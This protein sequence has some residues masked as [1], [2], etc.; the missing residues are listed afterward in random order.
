MDIFAYA[1]SINW[2]A[3][4][5]DMNT[6]YIYAI[7]EVAGAKRFFGLE[8]P[9]PVYDSTSGEKIGTVSRNS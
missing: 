8:L 5:L 6:G 3:D 7:T 9:I 1:D 2:G 4:Y